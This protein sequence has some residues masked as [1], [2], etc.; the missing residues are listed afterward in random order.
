M[1]LEM[2]LALKM[3][4][5]LVMTPQLQQAIKLLQLSHLEL[6]EQIAEEMVENPALEEVPES[7]TAEE[8][9]EA[10]GPDP[11][12]S[13]EPGDVT[14]PRGEALDW[15][16][17]SGAD[18]APE[19]EA[20]EPK[21]S[22]EVDWEKYLDDQDRTM[23]RGSLGPT[24]ADDLPPPETNLTRSD[25][26]VDHLIW[27]M[28][29]TDFP[30]NEKEI[31]ANV[32][33]N[34]NEDGYLQV[35]ADELAADLAVPVE[36]VE[37]AIERVQ[38]FDPLG[39][40]SRNLKECL[41]IQARVLHPEDRL[42]AEV[43]TNHL[44]D[45]EKRNYQAIARTL[46]VGLSR[47]GEI[48]RVITE[49]EPRPG[50]A[51]SSSQ[52]QY[53]TPDVYVRKISGE[54]VIQLNEDGLPRLRVSPYVRSV[55]STANRDEKEYMKERLRSAQWLIKSIHQRQRT[56]YRVV[57]SIIK[58]QREFLDHGISRLKP[59]ILRDVADDIG[60]HEST[61][62]RVTTNKYV[63]T[64]QGTYELKFFFNSGISRV[65]GEDVAS[66]M[67]KDKIRTIISGENPHKP[68]SDQAIVNELK[69]QNIDIARRTVAKYREMLGIL[70]SSRRK[71]II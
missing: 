64:P 45:L 1:A 25:T 8:Q 31:A 65:H 34:L 4:Q 21:K 7:I 3:Q 29:L 55:L 50:R 39:V 30:Q 52:A 11:G 67:V 63:H 24:F 58:H 28:Q 48:I 46:G 32:I 23:P 18:K 15:D 36:R 17:A 20:A 33:G 26:L 56:I 16:A 19:P 2:K 44:H 62:S 22:D 9:K 69:K 54:Y 71:K 37:A 47:I 12:E 14:D 68:F 38:Q 70:S 57:E 13:P 10:E 6:A 51:F 35:S 42:L 5:Q 27:Q 40:A 43:V 60:M 59:M 53:I 49:M 66:E 41:V 61:I